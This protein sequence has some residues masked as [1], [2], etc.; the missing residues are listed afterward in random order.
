MAAQ[1]AQALKKPTGTAAVA[2]RVIRQG[3]GKPAPS[4]TVNAK[5]TPGETVIPKELS[6]EALAPLIALYQRQGHLTQQDIEQFLYPILQNLEAG[7]EGMSNGGLVGFEQGGM[8]NPADK[9]SDV[10][11]DQAM[12]GVADLIPAS[13]AGK[14]AGAG[15]AGAGLLLNSEE[16]GAGSDQPTYPPG[17]PEWQQF[18]DSPQRNAQVVQSRKPVPPSAP[19]PS[20]TGPGG[21]TGPVNEVRGYAGGGG[22][23]QVIKD[24]FTPE[25]VLRNRREVEAMKAG[26]YQG[27]TI[28]GEYKRV[29]EPAPTQPAPVATGQ[30]NPPRGVEKAVKALTGRKQQIDKAV[31]DATG[32]AK[33][34]E[35]PEPTMNNAMTGSPVG[36]TPGGFVGQ[37]PGVANPSPAPT[38]LPGPVTLDRT[39]DDRARENIKRKIMPSHPLIN[40]NIGLSGTIDDYWGGDANPSPSPTSP[41]SVADVAAKVAGTPSSSLA[42]QPANV[43]I[44]MT[45][46]K[47]ENPDLAIKKPDPVNDA[48]LGN[49]PT[50]PRQA[51]SMGNKR[52]G[53]NVDAQGGNEKVVDGKVVPINTAVNSVPSG[54]N[55]NQP[56]S[57]PERAMAAVNSLKGDSFF[58]KQGQASAAQKAAL[59]NGLMNA[60]QEGESQPQGVAGVARRLQSATPSRYEQE[61]K[62]RNDP[63]TGVGGVVYDLQNRLA[64]SHKRSTA[65]A[66]AEI[67]NVANARDRTQ[68]EGGLG[69]DRINAELQGH[70]L[71]ADAAH[72]RNLVDAQGNQLSA[73][74]KLAN[75]AKGRGKERQEGLQAN[76]LERINAE[77]DQAKK[78]AILDEYQAV[79]GS[80]KAASDANW[81]DVEINDGVDELRNPKTKKIRMN[82]KTGE[83]AALDVPGQQ[84]QR[85]IPQKG[86]VVNGHKFLGGNPA[87][88]KS[89]SKV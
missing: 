76:Y 23:V 50:V 71:V 6:E 82:R 30:G 42:N 87:D 3:G 35:I 56:G 73:V 27:Q 52:V 53:Y 2:Q 68:M 21:Y 75:I 12:P 60:G 45:N 64:T 48:L 49:P 65:N 25:N 34:G 78:K 22:V 74:E 57:N 40:P 77:Q 9:F 46:W 55:I 24:M 31:R 1:A 54:V 44:D 38:A 81:T 86:Q 79:F 80:N 4:D 88:P 15:M 17:S 58:G 47:A 33:G 39:F 10:L 84:Q 11:L 62:A 63:L 28:E 13:V 69:Q 16:A 89:W 5:L 29:E 83:T 67:L 37:A 36:S 66:L 61:I 41:Q 18:V 43:G 32:Y 7:E 70:E 72:E 51:G 85:P 14:M 8:A 26:T 19:L 20:P 59:Y